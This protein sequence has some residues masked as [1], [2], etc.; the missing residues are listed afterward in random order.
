MEK[1]MLTSEGHGGHDDPENNGPGGHDQGMDDTVL[2]G[3]ED[4]IDGV[5]DAQLPLLPG[6]TG[7]RRCV[8]TLV[9]HGRE[10]SRVWQ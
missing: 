6:V 8:G 9:V 3:G 4:V 1:R 10:T 5:D 7:A 2:D